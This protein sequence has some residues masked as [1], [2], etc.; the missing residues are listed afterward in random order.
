MHAHR[1]IALAV[2]LVLHVV[3]IALLVFL[4]GRQI[5]PHGETPMEVSLAASP[6]AA[7][8]APPKDAGP[9]PPPPQVAEF[10]PREAVLPNG[11][12]LATKLPPS[13]EERV[14]EQ[15]TPGAYPQPAEKTDQPPIRA[16]PD[17]DM[18]AVVAAVPPPMPASPP[19]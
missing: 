9:S 2:S 5:Q 6:G 4:S 17:A 13:P 15:T 7:S 1:T 18:P 3:V 19:A 11:P 8:G 10:A 12:Q 14:Q 16:A